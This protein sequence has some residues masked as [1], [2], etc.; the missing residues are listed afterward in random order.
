M[1]SKAV[2]RK[3]QEVE[4]LMEKLKKAVSFY[5]V[6]Y[7]GL[8]ANAMNSM[9]G[10]FRS[11][12]YEYFV[13]K[14]SIL[15]RASERLG[16]EEINEVLAGPNSISISYDDPIGPARIINDNYKETELPTMQL[17]YIEGKWFSSDE[18]RK[19]A[20]L[21]S[22]DVLAGQMLNV[23]ISPISGFVNL[24]QTHLSGLLRVVDGMCKKITEERPPVGE[25][26]TK[27]P[28]EPEVEKEEE[29]VTLKEPEETIEEEVT[30]GEKTEEQSKDDDKEGDR[31]GEVSTEDQQE[32]N[33]EEK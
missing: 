4:Q 20:N 33:K 18:A 22:R 6:D 9:R 24:L 3:K 2:A 12:N 15:Q 25:E 32:E 5:I 11:D 27:A 17:C 21:P 19:L 26:Q 30:G 14:N 13:I 31:K 7:T 8:D 16:F 10:K 1:E 29:K 23:L 28:E